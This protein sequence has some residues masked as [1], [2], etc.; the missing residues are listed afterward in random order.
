MSKTE[1]NSYL[2]KAIFRQKDRRTAKKHGGSVKLILSNLSTTRYYAVL[3]T[4]LVG[5]QLIYDSS[6]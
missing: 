3:Y 5:Y 6:S 2:I 1:F 4:R